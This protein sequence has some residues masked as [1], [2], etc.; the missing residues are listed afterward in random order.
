MPGN[1]T[2]PQPQTAQQAIA[3]VNAKS[4]P[5]A[6]TSQITPS[7]AYPDPAGGHLALVQNLPCRR[8]GA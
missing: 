4:D 3:R 2:A 7:T 6:S 1:G 8:D 5:A